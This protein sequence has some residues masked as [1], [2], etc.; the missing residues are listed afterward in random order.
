ML[1]RCPYDGYRRDKT[2]KK[3][4]VNT[5]FPGAVQ[6]LLINYSLVERQALML[7]QLA[8]I[9]AYPNDEISQGLYFWLQLAKGCGLVSS[10][11]FDEEKR[12]SVSGNS[13]V[14]HRREK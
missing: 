6:T 12:G 11:G 9:V 10:W 7:E 8:L 2:T 3:L 4:I 1:M 5:G 13:N 14:I